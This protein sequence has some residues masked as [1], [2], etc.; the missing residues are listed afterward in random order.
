MKSQLGSV[1]CLTMGMVAADAVCGHDA[2]R[3]DANDAERE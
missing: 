1:L 3:D 2:S